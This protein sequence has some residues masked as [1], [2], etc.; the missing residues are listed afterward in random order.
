MQRL[1]AAVLAAAVLAPLAA[2]AAEI[3][4][5]WRMKVGEVV[6]VR[7][8][9]CGQ[10]L[11]GVVENAES[12]RANPDALDAKN[13]DPRLRTRKIKGSPILDGFTPEG[14]AWKGRI[15]NPGNGSSLLAYLQRQDQDRM[16]LKGCLAPMM[17]K[18]FTLT[19]ISTGG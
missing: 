18:N 1:L 19:R 17:C 7:F 15:Y 16:I 10:A 4:G 13:R 12:L 6:D 8:T 14:D 3:S 5:A 2:A 11:C 9:P